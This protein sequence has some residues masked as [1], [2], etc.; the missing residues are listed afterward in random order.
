MKPQWRDV[1][2]LQYEN[3]R[4]DDAIWL[5][6]LIAKQFPIDMTFKFNEAG[7]LY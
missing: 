3:M 6:K 5:P 1:D 7:K 2:K 4:E